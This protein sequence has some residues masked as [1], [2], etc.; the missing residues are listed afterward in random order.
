[1]TGSLTLAPRDALRLAGLLA[2]A[3]FAFL[4]V[5]G[6]S[7]DLLG[8]PARLGLMLAWP[9][10]AVAFWASGRAWPVVAYVIA[11]G[12]LMRWVELPP[13]GAGPSDHLAATY[14]AIDVYLSGGN[15]YDHVYQLTRPPG[16]PVSQ[17]PGELLLHLPGYLL[18]GLG[19]VQ[20]TQFVLAALTMGGLAWAAA[21]FSWL[22]GL[23][24]LALYAG[25]PNLVLLA[26]DGSNDTGVAALLLLAVLALAWAVSRGDQAALL[27]A[28]AAAAFAVSTKQLA[29][30]IIVALA[31]VAVQQV[32]WRR[33]GSYLLGAA[34][35][36]LI[37]SIPFLLMGPVEFF[38][39]LLS[40]VGAHDDIYGWNLWAFVQGLGGTPWDSGAAA[41]LT[42]IVGGAALVGLVLVRWR[43]LTGAVLGGV[44]A[45][46]LVMFAARWTTYAYFGLVMPVAMALPLLFAW[47]RRGLQ[48]N[49]AV[50]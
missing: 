4:L 21:R 33:G 22:A 14:E 17:P 38:S 20:F 32:G 50:A 16:S 41:I 29:L 15:P 44:I 47:E 9:A 11:G 36:L 34:W 24:A 18:G 19:G 1:M 3:A 26:T 25:A 46:L 30:P 12:L 48:A 10:V 6:R 5:S 39:A 31:S 45:T 35:L 13:G 40:F 23:P 27:T 43:S 7:I 37:L 8:S 2:L 49:E 42:I 28:G